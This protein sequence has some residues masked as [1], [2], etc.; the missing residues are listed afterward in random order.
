[1]TKILV[2]DNDHLIREFMENLLTGL[3]HEVKVADDG[4]SALDILAG[5]TPD[6]I[7]VDLIMPNIDGRKLCKIIR[8]SK[9][10]KDVYI[11]IL[12]GIAAE[13]GNDFVHLGANACV[14]K[15]PLDKMSQHILLLLNRASAAAIGS[16]SDKVIG[17]DNTYPRAVA[18]ELLSATRHFE[19]ILERMSEGIMEINAAGRIIYANPA[20]LSLIKT[21]EEKLLGSQFIDLF[22]EEERREITD[23]LSAENEKSRDMPAEPT[24]HLNG[25]PVTIDKLPMN[26]EGLD[27][28]IILN[29]ISERK[30]AEEALRS[31]RDK[32]QGVL[33][34][35]AEGMYIINEEYTVEFQ[36]KVYEKLFPDAIGKK[37]YSAYMQLH[38][39]CDFC[40]SRETML[41][42][43]AKH[44]EAIN[45][46]GTIYDV[47]FSPFSDADGKKKVIVLQ[48]DTTEEKA[49]Q[50]EALRLSHLASLGE[51]SAGVAH[52]I[53][54]PINSIINYAEIL[55]EQFN[56]R[57]EDA[58]IPSR[59]IREGERIAQI[60]KNLLSLARSG[61]EERS[62]CHIRD[63]LTGTL[64][65]I[66]RN[67]V[68]DGIKLSMEVPHGLPTIRARSQEIQQVFLNI[69]SNARYAL[70]K[71]FADA[72]E[73]KTL[74][75]SGGS[76]TKAGRRYV[77]IIFRD[78]GIGIPANLMDRVC[79]PF[80]STKPKDE[81]TGLGLSISHGIIKSHEGNLS[82]ESRQGEFTEVM[83]EL[84]EDDGSRKEL[85]GNQ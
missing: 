1:M 22:S 64:D 5:Y 83:V 6:I 85:D 8:R 55:R 60:V 84:P 74:I 13:E 52:E 45:G 65:L 69:L 51:L 44:T 59:I 81:G 54:N 41:T 71:K 38:E 12:T 67:I 14:A 34:A 9:R 19:L 50:A 48:R 27:T 31:E 72:N 53:N 73:E 58:D 3:G 43:K 23:L 26:K 42:G 75:I 57:N 61:K 66:E 80:F 77:Q 32:F 20:A 56:K 17:V 62:P 7:F 18:K 39:P 16:Q 79:N 78:S 10:F 82:F 47:F 49:I 33:Y 25:C 37:C 70:N 63:I 40:L 76:L 68:N 11:I 21:P 30:R 28:I 2:V 35:I 36:N 46:R 4:L 15:G 29:D 24:F